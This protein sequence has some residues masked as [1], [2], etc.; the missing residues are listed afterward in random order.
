MLDTA[1]KSVVNTTASAPA[2]PQKIES[3]EKLA[4]IVKNKDGADKIELMNDPNTIGKNLD[5]ES[6]EKLKTEFSKMMKQTEIEY[7][8]D[9]DTKRLV[10]KLQDKETKKVISQVPPEELLSFAKRIM[11]LLDGKIVN[12]KV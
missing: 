12:M 8:I 7:E 11:E 1:V 10:F 5:M 9:A 6:M 4:G 2:Y 3:S